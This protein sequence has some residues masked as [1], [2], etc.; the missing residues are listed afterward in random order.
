MCWIKNGRKNSINKLLFLLES[1]YKLKIKLKFCKN[2]AFKEVYEICDNPKRDKIVIGVVENT[3][4]V[5]VIEK[6]HE[7]KGVFHVLDGS[8]SYL[9]NINENNLN[10]KNSINRI[11]K[12]IIK[13]VII[14]TSLNVS[15]F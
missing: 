3:E 14:H 4:D 8:F 2:C 12:D 1:I 5:F 13:K 11:K 6:L 15:G 7:Y 10:I 9:D